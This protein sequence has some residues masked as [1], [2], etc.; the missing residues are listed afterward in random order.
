MTKKYFTL[1][2]ANALIPSLEYK[3]PKLLQIK[4]ELAEFVSQLEKSGTNVEKLLAANTTEDEDLTETKSK[5]D[6]L[7]KVLNAAIVD[8]Q[9][10]GC[11]IKDMDLGLID[12]RALIE[13][14]EID[15]CW[16]LGEKEISYW[17]GVTE[18]FAGRKPLYEKDES[19][20][21]KQYH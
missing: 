6:K 1:E 5:L 3:I 8:I 17:H 18:G 11:I 21:D 20:G 13:D 14:E 4:K 2:E 16:Q 9:S 19:E 12:F 10:Y 15:F 7:G